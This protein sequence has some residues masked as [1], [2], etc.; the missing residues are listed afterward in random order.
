MKQGTIKTLG[1]AALGA[2]FAV[3]AAGT[4]SAAPSV[5]AAD[6]AGLLNKL[7]V[8]QATET[9]SGATHAVKPADGDIKNPIKTSGNMVGGLPL[10]TVTGVAGKLP[11]KLP[12][13]KSVR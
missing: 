6:A 9:V 7:P 8:K 1:A 10:S 5:N 11:A 13:T 4:A 2:A 3:A 12:L